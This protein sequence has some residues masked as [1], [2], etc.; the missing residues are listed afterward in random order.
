M[1]LWSPSG[2]ISYVFLAVVGTALGIGTAVGMYLAPCML[3]DIIT[4][5]Y[6]KTGL[7]R[8]ATFSS[9]FVFIRKMVISVT[10]FLISFSYG[11]IGNF[12][13]NK[14]GV[15]SKEQPK[16]MIYAI[17]Y[18]ISAV[19]LF[20]M[21]LSFAFLYLYPLDRKTVEKNQSKFLKKG[22]NKDNSVMVVEYM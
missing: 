7:S 8:E 14:K 5:D 21:L 16:E 22:P 13:R 1:L 17:R 6:V 20:F 10:S 2:V 18:I 3:T 9:V 19:P 15:Y 12:D 4:E 11:K